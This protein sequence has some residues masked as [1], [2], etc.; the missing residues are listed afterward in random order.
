MGVCNLLL[1]SLATETSCID[2]SVRIVTKSPKVGP[3]L[4]FSISLFF[5]LSLC[6]D[7]REMEMERQF[8][9]KNGVLDPDS[10]LKTCQTK[11]Q[12]LSVPVHNRTAVCCK[13]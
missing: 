7:A 13:T 10:I 4:I 6:V 11:Q 2:P 1:G 5:Y 3:L 9:L 12:I 8:T